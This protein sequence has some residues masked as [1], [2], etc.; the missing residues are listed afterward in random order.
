MNKL[1]ITIAAALIIASCGNQ[2][3]KTE[4]KNNDKQFDQFKTSFVDA[5]WKRYP[6]WASSVGFHNYD[7]VL[8]IPNQAEK[9]ATLLFSKQYV[10][11]LQSFDLTTLSENNKTDYY[12]I[13]NS[14][15][16]S[17]WYTNDFKSANWNPSEYNIGGS[18]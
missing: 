6:S 12:L 3:Q 15:E 9:E 18:F 8:T 14:L 10:D 7:S 11:S 1:L 13:K 4:T 5:L 2:A 17:I 16:S